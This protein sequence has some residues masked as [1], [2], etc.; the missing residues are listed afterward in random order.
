MSALG[1]LCNCVCCIYDEAK[2]TAERLDCIVRQIILER[3]GICKMSSRETLAITHT[4]SQVAYGSF[5]F[6]E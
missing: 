1:G 4:L 6:Y 5:E 2:K 3:C